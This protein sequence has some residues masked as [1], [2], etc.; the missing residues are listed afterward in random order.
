MNLRSCP[1]TAAGAR[2]T[3][4][5]ER[6]R[7]AR[8]TASATAAS[9]RGDKLADRGGADGASSASAAPSSARRCRS[10][11][12]PALVET[13]H[14]VGTFVTGRGDSAVF[15]IRRDQLATLR[16]VVAMLELRIGVETEAAGLAAQ[17]RSDDNLAAMRR[18]ARS[19]S[20]KPW[21]PVATQW[22][23]TSSSTSRSR[24]RPRTR[25]S[26]PDADARHGDRFRA[27]GS[28]RRPRRP[29]SARP[30]C[31]AS[32]PSTAA[33]STR[34][35]TRTARRR[36][37]RCAPTSPTAASGAAAR[38]GQQLTDPGRTTTC[39]RGSRRHTRRPP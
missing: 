14:G 27:P 36:A 22:A 1:R 25:I 34:S 32:T 30:T 11:R 4:R 6:G 24:A 31:A 38:A 16:D 2:A 9:R 13:R 10:C 12:R 15:R 28:I 39:R 8:P 37:R 21:R 33:S 3:W 17:R 23:L 26:E 19:P 5:I 29:T 18:R 7:G 35:R 20:R